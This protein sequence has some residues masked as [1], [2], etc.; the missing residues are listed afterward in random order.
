MGDI[1]PHSPSHHF[2]YSVKSFLK[3]RRGYSKTA[4][5][6]SSLVSYSPSITDSSIEIKYSNLNESNIKLFKAK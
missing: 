3:S 2:Q 4:Q 1:Y 5:Y 6:L